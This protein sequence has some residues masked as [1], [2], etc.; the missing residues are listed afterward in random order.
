MDKNKTIIVILSIVIVAVATCAIAL[1]L[2]S[3][4]N[5]AAPAVAAAGGQQAAVP[6]A[7]STTDQATAA[8]SPASNVTQQ[9]M[10]VDGSHANYDV[11]PD[12]RLVERAAASS[13]PTASAQPTGLVVSGGTAAATPAPAAPSPSPSAKPKA[14]PAPAK[15]AKPATLPAA[16]PASAPAKHGNVVY[17]IQVISSPNK[18]RVEQVQKTLAGTG[19]VGRI[20]SFNKA[21]SDYFRLRYGP[22]Y[23]KAEANKFLDWVKVIKGLE[24]SYVV[25]EK[26]LA[27]APKAGGAK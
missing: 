25:P 11:G 21:G 13:T 18:D 10:I 1:W 22:Y 12:G 23:E 26:I 15:T 7:S 14:S 17:W 3:S 4:N 5:R 27:P 19:F 6:S 16:A 8:P 20:S 24:N 9:I 2:L